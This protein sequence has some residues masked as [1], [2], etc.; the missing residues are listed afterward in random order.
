MPWILANILSGRDEDT[1]E[2]LM[3]SLSRATAE[4]LDVPLDTVRVVINEVDPS[5]WGVGGIRIDRQR[6]GAALDGG[7][8]GSA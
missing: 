4:A 6:A 2:K 3:A 5:R 8:G 7:D 1:M